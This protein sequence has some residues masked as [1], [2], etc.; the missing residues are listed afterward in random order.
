MEEIEIALAPFKV[1]DKVIV[2]GYEGMGEDEIICV[3]KTYD[4]DIKYKTKNHLDTHYFMG[5][6]LM[7]VEKSNKEEKQKLFQ[8]I[9]DNGLKWNPETKTLEKLPKFK[10]GDKI[11]YKKGKNIDGDEQQ[12]VII[13]ITDDTYDVAVTNDMGI[14]VPITDQYEWE[15]I[16]NKFDIANLKP[17][18]KVLVRQNVNGKWGIDFFGF[19]TEGYYYTTGSCIYVQCIPYENNEHLLGKVDDCDECFKT[20]E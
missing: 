17:F 9:K 18:E 2:K 1:G 12:G 15:L 10:V 7:K 13:S 3:F 8:A 4:G 20:W 11:K 16:P 5:D 6:S 19:Y 14:F